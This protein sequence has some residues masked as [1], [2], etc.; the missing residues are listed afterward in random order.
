MAQSV[1]VKRVLQYWYQFVFIAVV[2]TILVR[3]LQE[4]F[5][6]CQGRGN[7]A[8]ENL[9]LSHI[10]FTREHSYWCM[11]TFGMISNQDIFVSFTNGLPILVDFKQTSSKVIS[12]TKSVRLR[13]IIHNLTII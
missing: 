7:S 6:V 12:V 2:L 11:I 4:M 10:L 3:F 8:T 5:K 9:L 1:T 13:I